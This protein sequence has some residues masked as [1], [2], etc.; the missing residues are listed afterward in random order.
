[1]DITTMTKDAAFCVASVRPR[2]AGVLMGGRLV[3]A[4]LPLQGIAPSSAAVIGG[5]VVGFAP[6]RGDVTVEARTSATY[7]TP[8]VVRSRSG[9]PPV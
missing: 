8:A 1:M 4:Q 3:A 2:V 6:V 9:R 5:R 7:T